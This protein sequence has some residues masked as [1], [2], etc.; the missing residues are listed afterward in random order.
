MM[1]GWEMPLSLMPNQRSVLAPE[2]LVGRLCAAQG[3]N[4]RV[5]PSVVCGSR[6]AMTMLEGES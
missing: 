4:H 5:D 6:S 1:R 3:G 2:K